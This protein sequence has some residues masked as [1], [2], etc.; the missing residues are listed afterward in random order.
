VNF[1]KNGLV[2]VLVDTSLKTAP[3]RSTSI[4]D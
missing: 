4:I 3:L 1:N 2:T